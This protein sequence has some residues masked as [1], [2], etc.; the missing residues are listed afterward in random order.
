MGGFLLF[1]H[2]ALRTHL[3]SALAVLCHRKK[4]KIH[5]T[6]ECLAIGSLQGGAISP[7]MFGLII[8]M[9]IFSVLSLQ[10]AKQELARQQARNAAHDKAQ[11]EDMAKAI[12]F[13][14]LT[15]TR[16]NYHD[17][18]DVKRAMP[19]TTIATG[20]TR[21][22][23]QV[24]VGVQEQDPKANFGAGNTRVG[25]TASDDILRRAQVY[26]AGNA[27][28]ILALAAQSNTTV[29]TFDT[30]AVRSKQMRDSTSALE[31]MA[32]QIY[33]FYAGN[34]RFPSVGEYSRLAAQF[35]YHD[36]WGKPFDYQFGDSDNAALSFTTPWNYTYTQKLNLRDTN[37]QQQTDNNNASFVTPT[38]PVS[39]TN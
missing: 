6:G 24:M 38:T 17:D 32:E 4:A 29:V 13:S 27:D 15:E 33:A 25:V 2:P 10:W 7:F 9:S 19:Y 14:M 39:G 35:S 34:M 21:G 22:G 23:E 1:S 26:R 3:K 5:P 16:D 8:G 36:A 37:D 12:Q 11:A 20:K 31:G 18:I 30:S 28:D